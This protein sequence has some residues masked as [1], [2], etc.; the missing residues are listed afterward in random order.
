MRRTKER[1]RRR[2]KLTRAQKRPPTLAGREMRRGQGWAEE[3]EAW[4]LEGEA[5]VEATERASLVGR[6]GTQNRALEGA[7]GQGG[8]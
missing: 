5:R 4:G 3:G 7:G 2:R 6:D 8:S 1:T